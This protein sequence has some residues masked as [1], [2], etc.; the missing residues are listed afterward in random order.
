MGCIVYLVFGGRNTCSAMYVCNI[1]QQAGWEY[2]PQQA[3]T[4]TPRPTLCLHQNLVLFS[5]VCSN[6]CK[7]NQHCITLCLDSNTPEIFKSKY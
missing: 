3:P 6:H 7:D 2:L 1:T 5:K 4:P